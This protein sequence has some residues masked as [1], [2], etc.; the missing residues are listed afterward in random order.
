LEEQTRKVEQAERETDAA[1]KEAEEY[2]EK[3]KR[4]VSCNSLV[5][6]YYRFN[7]NYSAAGLTIKDIE[8]I[9]QTILLSAC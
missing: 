8:F 4:K 5:R 1:Y 9:I 3:V 6:L 2:L 7:V